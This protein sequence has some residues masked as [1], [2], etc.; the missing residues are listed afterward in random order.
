MRPVR[1][2]AAVTLVGSSVALFAGTSAASSG[3]TTVIRDGEAGFDHATPLLTH[4]WLPFES[5]TAVEPSIATNPNNP[6]NAVASYQQGRDPNGGSADLG[7]ATTIDGGKSWHSGNLGLT[8]TTGNTGSEFN[9]ASDPVVAFGPNNTVYESSLLLNEDM[10]GSGSVNQAALGVSVSKDGG[11]TWAPPTVMHLDD[12]SEVQTIG[13]F[14][15]KNWIGVDMGT[16]VGHHFGRV[17][18]VWDIQQVI[19]YAYCDPDNPASTKPG[20]DQASN[21][22]VTPNMDDPGT[23]SGFGVA[24]NSSAIGSYPLILQN[25]NLEIVFNDEG[26]AVTTISSAPQIAEVTT[27][28]PAGAVPWPAPLTFPTVETVVGS[29]D[30]VAVRLQRASPDMPTAA[31]DP[32]TGRVAVGWAGDKFRS[33][34]DRLNEPEVAV[35]TDATGQSFSAPIR[36][37]PATTPTNDNVDRYNAMLDWGP[38]SQLRVGWRQR[39]ESPAVQNFSSQVDTYYAESNDFG[40]T[41]TAPLQ[42]NSQPMNVGWCAFSRGGCFLGDYN[43]LAAAGDLTYIVRTEAT[44]PG[45][46]ESPHNV[47]NPPCFCSNGYD[48]TGTHQTA[49]VAVLGP[50]PTPNVPE[51]PLAPAMLVVGTAAGAVAV[52]A[53]RRRGTAPTADH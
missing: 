27:L 9:H 43:Q 38:G 3:G 47:G 31:V 20:C 24:Y 41:F 36:V 32:A 23:I 5:D 48:G 51:S 45:N 34:G 1:F 29:D 11:L 14:D 25:G 30:A 22:S 17:Y 12:A 46:G 19:L 50:A 18:V 21:W 53:R 40:A 26:A 49:W 8:S 6:L 16:G 39:Q 15:D 52:L 35:S 7:F 44:D 42:V 28:A 13:L 2:I 33:S 10:T 37:V 4:P